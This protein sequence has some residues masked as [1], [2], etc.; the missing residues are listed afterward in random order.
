MIY[1]LTG[2]AKSGK[3]FLSKEIKNTYNIPT[4]ST[5][6]IMMM[7]HHRNFDPSIDINASDSTVAKKLEPYIYSLIQAMIE[8]NETCLIEGVHFNTDFSA[9]LLLEFKDNL[10]IMYLGYKDITLETKM[11]EL[12]I[13]KERMNNP[14]LFNHQGQ[15]V[16]DIVTYMIEESKRVYHECN[17][18]NL[19]Y[20]DIYDINVQKEEIIKLFLKH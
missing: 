2:I 5:D 18:N 19:K 15:S 1:I 10:T 7:L 13:Y 20:V 14:W 12:Y 16:E 9:K 4:F 6:Y 11:S 8:N 3:T 17:T